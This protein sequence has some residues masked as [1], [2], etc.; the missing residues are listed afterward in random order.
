MQPES[1]ID[2]DSGCLISFGIVDDCRNEYIFNQFLSYSATLDGCIFLF[3]V[4]D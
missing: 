2:M 4:N 3:T 1:Y